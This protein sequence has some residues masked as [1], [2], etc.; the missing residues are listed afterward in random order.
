VKRF[1]ALGEVSFTF[2]NAAWLKQYENYETVVSAR[3]Q[4]SDA[5]SAEFGELADEDRHCST[6]DF[7]ADERDVYWKCMPSWTYF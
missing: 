4:T 3:T 7:K 2:S 5:F 1:G 6:Q